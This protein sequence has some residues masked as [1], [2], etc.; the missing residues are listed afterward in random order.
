MAPFRVGRVAG[1]AA[2]R[3]PA[4]PAKPGASPPVLLLLATPAL[5]QVPGDERAVPVHLDHAGLAAGALSTE[6]LIAAG[7][8][9][10]TARFATPDGAG[11]PAA[12]AA[13]VPTRRRGRRHPPA[14]SAPAVPTPTPVPAAM[15]SRRSARRGRLRDERL[16]GAPGHRVGFRDRRARPV[17]WSAGTTHLFGAGLLELLGPRDDRRPAG[18]SAADAL[19]RARAG[20]ASVTAELVTKGRLLRHD[21]GDAGGVRRRVGRRRRAPRPGRQ[22]VRPEGRDNLAAPDSR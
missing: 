13:E 16:R 7:E 19:G 1:E 22:A 17:E 5:A 14:S 10:F 15:S 6:D 18:D 11:R 21:H 9:L 4:R 8:R 3:Q 12:T 2:T 20:G